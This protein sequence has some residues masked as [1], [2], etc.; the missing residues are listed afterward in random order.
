VFL[1]MKYGVID[2]RPEWRRSPATFPKI[3][4]HGILE[5]AIQ[6]A[7]AGN[8]LSRDIRQL[9]DRRKNADY[10]WNAV[11]ERHKAEKALVLARRLLANLSRLTRQEWQAIADRLHSLDR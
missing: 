11:Y 10:E 4:V 7:P 6:A 3:K 2:L 1:E 5:K 8:I 9:S